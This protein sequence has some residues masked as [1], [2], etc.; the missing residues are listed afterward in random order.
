M[1]DP[2]DRN[3]VN[4][5]V[6]LRALL[7]G[8][9]AAA[10]LV[11]VAS[12][13]KP[14]ATGEGCKPRVAVVLMGTFASAGGTSVSLSVERSNKAGRPYAAATQPVTVAVD[15]KTKI[16][17]QGSAALADLADGDFLVVTARVCKADLQGG[18]VPALTAK[19]IVA[20]PATVESGE[21]Y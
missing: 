1:I 17:R 12:A 21:P 6:R 19:A 11:P 3:A 18:A 13:K 20:R 9:A 2:G 10:L 4:E 16:R 14:P 5:R 8:L 7:A 15:G